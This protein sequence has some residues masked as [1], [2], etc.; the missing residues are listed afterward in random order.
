VARPATTARGR[1]VDQDGKPWASI[2]V[3]YWTDVG[4]PADGRDGP[5][6]A[7]Q[8]VITDADGRFTAPGLPI[9]RRCVFQAYSPKGRE[10]TAVRASVED[11][12]AVALAPMVLR[13]TPEDRPR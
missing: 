10:N 3:V 6:G 4:L 7:V 9:G 12:Q 11:G 2:N 1:V 13:R 5:P 8:S